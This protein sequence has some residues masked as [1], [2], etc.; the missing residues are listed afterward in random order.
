MTFTLRERDFEAFFQAPFEAY[1]KDSLYVSHLKSDLKKFLT[2]GVNPLFA[3]DNDFTYFTVHDDQR[4]IGRIVAHVHRASNALYKDNKCFFGYFDCAN[5]QEAAALLLN[6]AQDW[7]RRNGFDQ[8][9]GSFNLTIAQQMGV[10]TDGFEHAPYLEMAYN[11]PHI[12][13]LLRANGFEAFFPATTTQAYLKDIDET[14]LLGPN[15]QAVLSDPDFEWKP[16]NRATLKKCLQDAH[17]LL[18]TSFAENPMFVPLTKEEFDFQT[19]SMGAIIDPRIA[20]I[21]YYKGQPAGA[22]I[23]IPDLNPL[24]K[25]IGSKLGITTLFH[26]LH[27]RFTR[28]R[29]LMVYFS[30]SPDLHNRGLNGAMVYRVM[31]SLKAAGYTQFGG[32]WT[33]DTNY[34]SLRAREKLKMGVMHTQHLFRKSL[35]A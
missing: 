25:K 35:T 3:S 17:H 13:E 30:V 15:Q 14:G 27:Y 18:N 23:C 4:V 20:T 8:I 16:I 1:G 12:P 22:V 2:A 26:F 6:A 10:V 5:N 7:G 31:Q 34:A 24:L 29:A 11:P 19:A 21:V 28:K 32:T 33:S 9:M